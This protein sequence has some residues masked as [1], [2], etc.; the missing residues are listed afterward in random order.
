MQPARSHSLPLEA[1]AKASFPRSGRP[2]TGPFLASDLA[3]TDSLLRFIRPG[4]LGREASDPKGLTGRSLCTSGVRP[5][6][7]AYYSRRDRR[8]RVSVCHVVSA[9]HSSVAF[10]C[11]LSRTSVTSMRSSSSSPDLQ[12]TAASGCSTASP[13]SLIWATASGVA[14]ATRTRRA[15]A[16]S[17]GADPRSL[18][19]IPTGTWRASSGRE[20]AYWCVRDQETPISRPRVAWIKTR[21]SPAEAEDS[22]SPSESPEEDG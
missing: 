5:I 11:P 9:S 6:S 16:A 21:N 19:S 22:T 14:A 17:E 4:A 3:T 18:G 15:D 13:C 20:G 7:P 1:R 2:N 10:L 12:H 8:L